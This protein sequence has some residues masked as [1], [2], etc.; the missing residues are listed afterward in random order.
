MV[1]TT[2]PHATIGDFSAARVML[3]PASP[4][5]ALSLAVAF[6]PCWRPLVSVNLN[7]VDGQRQHLECGGGHLQSAW[8][9]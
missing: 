2:I 7:E 6:V 5:T 9:P 4:G 1:G 8:N 3:R